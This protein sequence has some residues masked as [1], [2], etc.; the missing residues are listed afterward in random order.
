M[1]TGNSKTA[2]D[3][4]K[5]LT[6]SHQRRIMII[7]DKNGNLLTEE[8]AVL[9]RWTEYCEE[10]YN[11]KLRPDTSRLDKG[12]NT[13]QE[14]DDPPILEEEVEEAVR[15]LKGDKSPGVD[16]I[17]AELLKHAGPELIRTLTTICQ[18]IWITRQWPKEWTQSLIIP[19]PKKGNLK[20]CQNYR[21][22][23]LIS[24][25]AK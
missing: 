13:N 9:S 14:L 2:F 4:L 1:P 18:K 19:L 20:L 6:K 7:E 10:L 8:T 12:T 3:T 11:Y 22:I 24:H 16:N 25:P 17:P 21:T 23:S 15:S 5:L